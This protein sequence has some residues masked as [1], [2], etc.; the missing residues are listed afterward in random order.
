MIIKKYFCD[1]CKIEIPEKEAMES[2]WT[3]F[4]KVIKIWQISAY[5]LHEKRKSPG[6]LLCLKCEKI[7]KEKQIKLL[8]EMNITFEK[9]LI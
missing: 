2:I 1:S 8:N 3:P 9:E 5:G 4:R 7:F 6:F